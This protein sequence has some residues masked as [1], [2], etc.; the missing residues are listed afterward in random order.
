MCLSGSKQSNGQGRGLSFVY[1]VLDAV[2]EWALINFPQSHLVLDGYMFVLQR[3]Q[4][5]CM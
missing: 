5:S 4:Y 3:L 1:A 2:S